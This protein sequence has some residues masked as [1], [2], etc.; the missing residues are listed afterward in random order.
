MYDQSVT[1]TVT[2]TVTYIATEIVS[3]PNTFGYATATATYT[4]TN[5][6]VDPHYATFYASLTASISAS[7]S[8][9]ASASASASAVNRCPLFTNQTDLLNLNSGIGGR[10][11][12]CIDSNWPFSACGSQWPFIVPNRNPKELS[13]PTNSTICACAYLDLA[14]FCYNRILPIVDFTCLNNL[15]IN[16]FMNSSGTSDNY[17]TACPSELPC[18]TDVYVVPNL[19][20]KKTRKYKRSTDFECN[21]LK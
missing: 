6:N 1:A 12:G 9:R 20:V 21:C 14:S 16:T 15:S 7:N 13:I 11:S 5:T 18:N 3:I 17:N 4:A 2:A 10:Y 19:A 8:A